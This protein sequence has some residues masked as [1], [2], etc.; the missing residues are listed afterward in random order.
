[1]SVTDKDEP[2]RVFYAASVHDES[3]IEAVVD[4]LR[5]PR[6]LWVGRRVGAMERAIAPLF[7]RGPG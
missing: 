5:D 6:G 2:R 4:V 7:A 3:E 1:M